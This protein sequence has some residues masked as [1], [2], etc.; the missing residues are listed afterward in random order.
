MKAIRTFIIEQRNFTE[1]E[2]GSATI[3]AVLWMPIF[4][5]IFSM[6]ADA[7]L[8]FN[9][10]ANLTRLVQ[11]ANRNYS[12]GRLDTDIETQDYIKARLGTAATDAKT[13]VNTS[14]SNGVISTTVSVPAY[15]YAAIGFFTALTQFNISVTSQH[16]MES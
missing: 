8:L 4:V 12:I 14:V 3:E 7:S 5:L 6:I 11:D 9:A 16:M 15:H 13:T 1:K 10:Q 2:D